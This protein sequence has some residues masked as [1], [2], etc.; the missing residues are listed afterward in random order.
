MTNEPTESNDVELSQQ[1][2]SG[3]DFDPSKSAPADRETA[4][5]LDVNEVQTMRPYVDLGAIKVVP[6]EGLQLRL[7]VDQQAKRI[8]A[9][10]LDFEGSTLQVQAFSA[11]KSTGLWNETRFNIRQQLSA[12]GAPVDEVDG[13]FGPEI[14]ATVVLPEQ[15][16]GGTARVRFI[17]VDGP[18]WM[19]RGTITGNA[20]TNTEA[21]RAI[22]GIFRDLVIVRGDVPMPPNE[23]LPMKVPAGLPGAQ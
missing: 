13:E 17:G 5:P 9:V 21:A 15:R 20:I 16:G 11:P 19:L 23:L 8:V 3:E 7:D 6:R 10:S 12:Q 4:G 22:E 14:L 18:R 1:G 2:E